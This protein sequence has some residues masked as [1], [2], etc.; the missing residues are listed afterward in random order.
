MKTYEQVIG[1]IKVTPLVDVCIPGKVV[2]GTFRF[3]NGEFA[4]FICAW[5]EDG[6]DHVSVAPFKKHTPT[7]EQMCEVKDACFEDEEEAVQIHP[8]R[9]EYIN[10]VDNCLHLWAR[11]DGRRAWE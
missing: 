10:A 5:N 11:S 2:F 8:P 1:N 4:S 6:M 3:N 9:S 7:W